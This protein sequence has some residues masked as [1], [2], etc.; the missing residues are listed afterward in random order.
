MSPVSASNRSFDNAVPANV[1][2]IEPCDC[3]SSTVA[4]AAAAVNTISRVASRHWCARAYSE[5]RLVITAP[6]RGGRRRS[7]RLGCLLVVTWT[8]SWVDQALYQA[9]IPP[10][11]A[12]CLDA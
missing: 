8:N 9:L 6:V 4:I 2:E 5:S 11:G 7:C 10:Y 12:D 3:G 1:I